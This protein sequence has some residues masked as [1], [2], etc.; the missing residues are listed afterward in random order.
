MPG[1]VAS[2]H[3]RTTEIRRS[4]PTRRVAELWLVDA[5]EGAVEVWRPGAPE[6]EVVRDALTWTVVGREFEISMD[7]VFRG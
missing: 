2:L 7:E 1:C 5:D 4:S 6:P 3:S